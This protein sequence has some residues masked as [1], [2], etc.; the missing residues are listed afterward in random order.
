MVRFF[1][2]GLVGLS[3][4]GCQPEVERVEKIYEPLSQGVTPGNEAPRDPHGEMTP[5]EKVLF[6]AELIP[7]EPVLGINHPMPMAKYES[8]GVG[9]ELEKL[10]LSDFKKDLN[11]YQIYKFAVESGQPQLVYVFTRHSTDSAFGDPQTG[12]IAK[13]GPTIYN[14]DGLVE[15][16]SGSKK[17]SNPTRKGG[18]ISYPDQSVTYYNGS[19]VA[20]TTLSWTWIVVE[21]GTLTSELVILQRS[22]GEFKSPVIEKASEIW[23]NEAMSEW[24]ESSGKDKE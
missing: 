23:F 21:K 17:V 3:L 18:S 11:L 12:F 8:E 15:K 10:I 2:L 14:Y 16:M 24:R 7:A 9:D 19:I 5:A 4:C 1:L 13:G 6:E 20:D 22:K